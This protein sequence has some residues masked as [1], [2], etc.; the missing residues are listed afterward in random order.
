MSKIMSAGDHISLLIS[1][2]TVDVDVTK[3]VGE[4]AMSRH[5]ALTQLDMDI[6]GRETIKIR[7]N[8]RQESEFDLKLAATVLKYM[9]T[10]VDEAGNQIFNGIS[11]MQYE[12]VAG[13]RSPGFFNKIAEAVDKISG[14]TDEADIDKQIS[15]KN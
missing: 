14:I 12:R 13:L 7:T 15:E 3:F 5:R 9:L 4:E 10:A 11:N 8:K 1:A 2:Q 6:I